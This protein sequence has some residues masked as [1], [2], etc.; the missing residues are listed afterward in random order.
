MTDNGVLGS[1]KRSPLQVVIIRF[2]KPNKITNKKIEKKSSIF[3]FFFKFIKSISKH[4]ENCCSHSCAA[5]S[6]TAFYEMMMRKNFLSLIK[7]S[8]FF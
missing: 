4:E 5:C 1:T 8:K 6:Y 7:F 3:S 2:K